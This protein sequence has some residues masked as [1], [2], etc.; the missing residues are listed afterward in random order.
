MED[1]TRC[2]KL[3]ICVNYKRV[4]QQET[5]VNRQLSDHVAPPCT[6]F[7]TERC[8]TTLADFGR[9]MRQRWFEGAFFEEVNKDGCDEKHQ[10]VTVCF[11]NIANN[12]SSLID[13][14]PMLQSRYGAPVITYSKLLIGA[15]IS[16]P[17]WSSTNDDV[18]LRI[19]PL[20][21]CYTEDL[22]S[23]TVEYL[24]MHCSYDLSNRAYILRLIVLPNITD[25]VLLHHFACFVPIYTMNTLI[26][27]TIC[28]HNNNNNNNN[29]TND[30]H[31]ICDNN[32]SNS[33]ENIVTGD[34]SKNLGIEVNSI[35]WNDLDSQIFDYCNIAKAFF[36]HK[37]ENAFFGDS[38]EHFVFLHVAY[39]LI[40]FLTRVL[41]TDQRDMHAG[42]SCKRNNQLIQAKQ[43]VNL[44]YHIPHL[45]YHHLLY[46]FCNTIHHG[47]EFL[48][49]IANLEMIMNGYLSIHAFETRC[50]SEIVHSYKHVG[51]R[52]PDHDHQHDH[53][54]MDI[55]KMYYWIRKNQIRFGLQ[56]QPDGGGLCI[57]ELPMPAAIFDTDVFL[58]PD[59]PH[60]LETEYLARLVN[61]DFV[62]NMMNDK[63]CDSNNQ[64]SCINKRNY[65]CALTYI[66]RVLFLM[67]NYFDF[68]LCCKDDTFDIDNAT[69]STI[70]FMLILFVLI[71]LCCHNLSPKFVKK[72]RFIVKRLEC[73]ID[74]H[75]I[76]EDKVNDSKINK[77]NVLVGD[78]STAIIRLMD[79]RIDKLFHTLMIIFELKTLDLQTFLIG[80]NNY[81]YN[82]HHKLSN[83]RLHNL[84][85]NRINSFINKVQLHCKS[86][87]ETFES[88]I[89]QK[90][91][92]NVR[93][94]ADHSIWFQIGKYL[95]L[96]TFLQ[97]KEFDEKN[98]PHLESLGMAM[99]G[100][101]KE[102]QQ[103]LT[104][105]AKPMW[106][107]NHS[108]TKCTRQRFKAVYNCC[109]AFAVAVR[110]KMV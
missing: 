75:L 98:A 29:S 20:I 6:F 107:K 47:N 8:D 82:I 67:T 96:C 44:K 27:T 97:G 22:E 31:F 3:L 109:S 40:V 81:S 48:R 42:C 19:L 58:L 16:P 95:V 56:Y 68:M 72:M 88:I 10:T 34:H 62:V 38:S 77:F 37:H 13:I 64:F 106:A 52:Y 87:V 60:S 41:S 105:F 63:E 26:P 1:K 30:P 9:K 59:C 101:D 39:Y 5:I 28:S 2:V 65:L 80:C 24:L 89:Q 102:L 103:G 73:S 17:S 4:D 7:A 21:W 85:C 86:C 49:L 76:T 78:V 66:Q 54:L 46:M 83:Q 79:I 110:I 14:P 104:K 61:F 15:I 50:L 108:H 12:V 32:N 84:D 74:Q 53:Q 90:N 70:K 45:V 11:D 99:I 92:V 35:E 55:N 18:P 36:Y 57:Q 71:L 69:L 100:R 25:S 33:S 43:N 51:S 93:A 23:K 94:L 91:V